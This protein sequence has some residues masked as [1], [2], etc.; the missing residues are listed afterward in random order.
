M[1]DQWGKGSVPTLPPFTRLKIN[2]SFSSEIT[3]A[4]RQ[5]N[6]KFKMVKLKSSNQ[7]PSP[8]NT[9]QK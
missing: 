1:K 6:I 8:A 2:D 9:H 3:K 5:C 7:I 4:R